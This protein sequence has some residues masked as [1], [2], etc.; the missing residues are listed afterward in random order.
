MD[1]LLTGGETI[2]ECIRNTQK[3]LKTIQKADLYLKH[4]KCEFDQLKVQY[5]GMIIS[6]QSVEMDP[7]KL[8]G[9]AEWPTPK[10]VK[11]IQVFLGFT[12]FYRRFIPK[13]AEITRPLDLLRRKNQPWEWT[14]KAQESF[15]MLKRL[16]VQAPLLQLPDP[17]KP[18]YLETDASKYASGGVLRQPNG[19]GD[20]IPCGYISKAFTPTEQN[21]Q[22]YDR[23]LLALVQ[24]LKA[25]R[26][27]L[28]GSKFP[29]TVWCDHKNL[30][31]F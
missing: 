20:L 14:S 18:F 21:Y 29:I 22:I 23:E 24:A 17:T 5:L 3:C 10:K 28:L 26:H 15:D 27:Y 31:Y 8:A 19:N 6:N 4:T 7:V 16:F 30:T 12:N 13:Y 25:W 2:E 9:I 11:D 1:D